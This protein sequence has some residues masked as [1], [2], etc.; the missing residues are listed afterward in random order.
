[1][2]ILFQ[3]KLPDKSMSALTSDLKSKDDPYFWTEFLVVI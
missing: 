3:G 2:Y 1:M